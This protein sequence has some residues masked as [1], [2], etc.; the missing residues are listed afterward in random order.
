MIFRKTVLAKLVLLP[1][2][3]SIGCNSGTGRKESK[4]IISTTSTYIE[5]AIYDLTGGK[6][7]VVGLSEPN[8]CPG[9]FDL[10]VKQVELIRKSSLFIRFDFQKG[11]DRKLKDIPKDKIVSL[12]LKRGLCVPETY[13]GVCKQI[14]NSIVKIKLAPKALVANQ[15]RSIEKRMDTLKKTVKQKISA[16]GLENL[17]VIVSTHQADF[18]RYIGLNVIDTFPSADK[19]TLRQINKL[20]D[21]AKKYKVKIII[22]NLSEGDKLAKTLSNRLGVPYVIFANFPSRPIKVGSF[23]R[24]V[25]DNV[26][27]LVAKVKSGNKNTSD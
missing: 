20:I 23:D 14:A 19:A 26:K 18:C 12:G 22:A 9:H 21:K 10:K 3:I 6:I 15:L 7:K 24:M 27:N 13:L 2:L 4:A 1:I 11:L 17:P 5:S 8:M 16:N 25:I